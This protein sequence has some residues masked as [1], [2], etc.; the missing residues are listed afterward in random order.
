M[1]KLFISILVLFCTNLY[2]QVQITLIIKDSISKEPVVDC[3]VISKEGSENAVT[4]SAG[5]AILN[6]TNLGKANLSFNATGFENKS[7][8][9]DIA[10]GKIYFIFLL[11]NE[12]DVEEITVTSVRTNSRI[13]NNPT[14]IE[15]LGI[16]DMNEENGI[17][18]G[19]IMSLLGDIAGIQMQQVSA[20]SGNTYARV[21]GL[22]GRYTQILKDGMPLYGGMSGSFGIL[23]IPPLDL[24][25]IEI[26]KGSA[27]TLYGGDAIGGVINLV[28]KDPGQKQELSFTANQTS[29]KET[30]FNL[31]AAKRNKK[32]GYTFFTGYTTEKPVDVNKD[33]LS[34]VAWIHSLVIHPKLQFYL[35]KKSTLTFNY[36]GTM[37]TRK[38]GDMNYFKGDEI[39]SV[40][41]INNRIKRHSAD[42]KILHEINKNQ[43]IT[44]KISGSDF[45]Q[46]LDTKYYD[47]AINQKL[48]YSEFSYFKKVDKMSWVLGVNANGDQF[49][50]QTVHPWSSAAI[51]PNYSYFTLGSFIQNTWNVAK[52]VI[53]SGFRMDYHSQ[54]KFIPLPRLSLMYR[55]N[56]AITARLNGGL[57]YKVPNLGSYINPE[58]DIKIVN[59]SINLK[60]EKSKGINADVN[61]H[62]TIA[63]HTSITLNQAFFYSDLSQPVIDS[64]TI[65]NVKYMMNAEKSI[66]TAGLQTYARLEKGDWELYLGYV[67]THVRKMY[68]AKNPLVTVT[69]K[70]N[71]SAM[72]MREINGNLHAGIESSYIAGQVDQYY[73]PVKNYLLFAAMVMYNYKKVAFVLNGENLLDFRQNK[74]AKIYDG[75]LANPAFHQLW[76]PIDG[77]VINFSIKWKM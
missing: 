24:K 5:V 51:P 52:W 77:R 37:D 66:R 75:T 28:S 25:Q 63:R 32:L 47:L 18:P 7:I 56:S 76:A 16:D 39:D 33:G 60:L 49:N 27:S 22:N 46:L 53:E 2:A 21:Q 69:P 44:F 34:D 26:I 12:S 68:D 3:K 4:D 40:Y 57:G 54:Y 58:T 17:K 42:V 65:A 9:L 10:A 59:P 74:S 70:H 1:K 43:N 19:N 73:K 41:H 64:S 55:A 31:Y 61:Y 67:F 15:V 71:L 11:P 36:T 30:N 14:R 38:G 50:N 6:F 29:L 72:I 20:S 8:Q 45:N 23:Q 48:L 13:E 62:R 35:S